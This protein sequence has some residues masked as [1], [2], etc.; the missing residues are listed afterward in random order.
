MHNDISYG[1]INIVV[2]EPLVDEHFVGKTFQ[3]SPVYI[4]L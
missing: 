2:E 1:Y 4:A 3:L